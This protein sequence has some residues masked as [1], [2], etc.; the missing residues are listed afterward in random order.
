M[1]EHAPGCIL[2]AGVYF[3]KC[4]AC[5]GDLAPATKTSE[6]THSQL[7]PI[8][9]SDAAALTEENDE[10]FMQILDLFGAASPLR[11]EENTAANQMQISVS[12]LPS[13]SPPTPP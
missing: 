10:G 2:G 7:S 3:G 6:P 9:F 1:G 13:P 11:A 5:A 4:M 8:S 12:P